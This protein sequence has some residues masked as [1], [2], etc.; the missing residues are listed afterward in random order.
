[1]HEVTAPSKFFSCSEEH[2]PSVHRARDEDVDERWGELFGG[3]GGALD[4][5][6]LALCPGLCRD[7][8]SAL[9]HAHSGVA[10][11]VALPLNS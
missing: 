11:D 1:M 3:D 7:N 2:D 9:P 4:L 6:H 8:V 5:D 10:A